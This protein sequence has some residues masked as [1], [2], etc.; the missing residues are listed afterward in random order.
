MRGTQKKKMNNIT[1]LF[2]AGASAGTDVDNPI[3]P[4]VKHFPDKIHEFRTWVGNT[5]LNPNHGLS[6]VQ[7]DIIKD[8]TFAHRGCKEHASIDTFA[9]ELSLK[10]KTEEL[11]T[12]K[13]V[14]DAFLIYCQFNDFKLDKRYDAFIAGILTRALNDELVFPGTIKILSWNYDIQ[15]ELTS[16][17]YIEKI[18]DEAVTRYMLQMIPHQS[19]FKIIPNWFSYVKLN[20]SSGAEII[21]DSY[22]RKW[23]EYITFIESPSDEKF[24]SQLLRSYRERNNKSIVPALTFAWEHS[25]MAMHSLESAKAIAEITNTLIVIGYSFPSFNRAV[26]KALIRAMKNLR[27]IIIQVPDYF[28]T[29]AE[30]KV[31]DILSSIGRDYDTGVSTKVKVTAYPGVSEFFIPTTFYRDAILEIKPEG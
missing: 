13:R 14:L 28:I 6:N 5:V 1:Y 15:F 24:L 2:G 11:N 8:L 19:N 25:P 21:D 7:E 26:D 31:N 10:E 16:R 30:L 18:G 17:N 23:Q 29:E 22:Q 20:G 4:L 3:I 27:E 9:R 12:L